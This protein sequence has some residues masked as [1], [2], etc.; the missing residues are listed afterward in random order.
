MK[1]Y[2]LKRRRPKL[3]AYC[4]KPNSWKTGWYSVTVDMYGG[5]DI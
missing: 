5:A 3:I 4:K 2:R 1:W